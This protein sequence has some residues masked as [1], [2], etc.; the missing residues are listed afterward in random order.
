MVRDTA[1]AASGL[2]TAKS[3]DPSVLPISQ[4]A[5]G[6][7]GI[8]RR[9]LGAVVR[10][11]PWQGCSNRADGR[12]SGSERFRPHPRDLRCAGS[13]EVHSAPGAHEHAAAGA[14]PDE[15]SDICRKPRE[16]SHSALLEGGKDEKRRE[17]AFRLADGAR[18]PPARRLASC[19]TCSREAVRISEGSR[20][21]SRLLGVGESPRDQGSVRTRGMD[22]GG[23]RNPESGSK[24]SQ[25][26]EHCSARASAPRQ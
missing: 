12:R 18:S 21:R 17:Y 5:L 23:K 2:L 13:R 11:E 25:T 6:G 7:D 3:A 22:D 8:R 4:R 9:L 10:T 15:R 26:D 20:R 16:R 24:Q 14:R 19:V 1:L